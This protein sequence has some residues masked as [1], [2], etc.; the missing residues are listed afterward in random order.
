MRT[1]VVAPES[2]H[3]GVRACARAFGYEAK[4]IS[5]EQVSVSFGPVHSPQHQRVAV[6]GA[7]RARASGQAARHTSACRCRAENEG[8]PAVALRESHGNF[9]TLVGQHPVI[10]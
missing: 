7:G 9:T 8:P 6:G 2:E 3:E 1:R 10:L 5:A 4:S